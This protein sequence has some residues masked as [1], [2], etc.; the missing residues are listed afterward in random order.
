[1]FFEASTSYHSDQVIFIIPSGKNFTTLEK[2]IYP[3]ELITWIAIGLCYLTGTFVIFIIKRQKKVIQGFVFGENVKNPHFNMLIGFIGGS[4]K[5]SP[6]NDF[7]RFL[8]MM[9]LIYS[10]VIRS[11]YQGS[12]FKLMQ[13][14]EKHKEVQSIDEMIE[15]DFKFYLTLTMA[16]VFQEDERIKNR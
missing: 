4:Q 2:L 6:K 5:I 14:E 3:F 10:L 15:K 9:L 11:A 8:L 16:D 7:A 12:Y 1:L 13:S